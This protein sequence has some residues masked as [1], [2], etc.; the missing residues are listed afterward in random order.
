MTKLIDAA[1]DPLPDNGPDA[2]PDTCWDMN[3]WGDGQLSVMIPRDFDAG[4]GGVYQ[5]SGVLQVGLR[6]LLLEYLTD[7]RKLD[8][9]RGLLP[10]ANLLREVADQYEAAAHRHCLPP[11]DRGYI[12]PPEDAVYP[13][14]NQFLPQD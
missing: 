14:Q 5:G 10:L 3:L 1:G 7:C 2:F 8:E 11:L 6:D 9:G 12:D 13:D 4:P